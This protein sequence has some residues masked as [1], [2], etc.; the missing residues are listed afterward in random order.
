MVVQ[1][2]CPSL[3]GYGLWF[4]DLDCVV[5]HGGE[6]RNS[7]EDY[8]RNCCR[9]GGSYP[10]YCVTPCVSAAGWNKIVASGKWV[11]LCA[12]TPDHNYSGQAWFT[13]Q[14]YMWGRQVHWRNANFTKI[15]DHFSSRAIQLHRRKANCTTMN[16]IAKQILKQYEIYLFQSHTTI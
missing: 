9:L 14:I 7:I 13:V 3:S 1:T 8:G 15:T 11:I 10:A 2:H 16:I 6:K 12:N 5:R 4:S